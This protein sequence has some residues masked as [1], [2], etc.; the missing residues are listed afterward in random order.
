MDRKIFDLAFQNQDLPSKIVAGLERVANA[1][2]VLLWT[3][4]KDLGLSPIQIQLLIFVKYH[5]EEQC[6]VSALAKAFNLTKPTISDAVRVLHQKNLIEKAPSSTDKRGYSIFL[7]PTGVEV[8]D[9]TE[10]FPEPVNAI[11]EKWSSQE[12]VQFF[13]SLNQLIFQLNRAGVLSVQRTC[14]G[15]RF[16]EKNK[17]SHYCKWLDQPLY[18]EDIRIDCPEF[19]ER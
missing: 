8:V 15:C 6:T 14:F 13:T 17:G 11:V 2:R 16:Y 3:Y 19:Q 10:Q 12:Q 1:F 7:T 9:R 5:P 18:D 4:A